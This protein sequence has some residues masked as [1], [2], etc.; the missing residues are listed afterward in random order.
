MSDTDKY[1][2]DN[3]KIKYIKGECVEGRLILHRVVRKMT[4]R[5]RS[6]HDIWSIN[7]RALRHAG[8]AAPASE[9]EDRSL[10][11][12]HSAMCCWIREHLLSVTEISK[13][14]VSV[15]L[16]VRLQVQSDYDKGPTNM[17]ILD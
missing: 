16:L 4:L 1:C 11:K 14:S 2:G 12:I 3:L 5:K 15:Y 8:G 6:G 10:C 9:N 13:F 7:A 17:Y